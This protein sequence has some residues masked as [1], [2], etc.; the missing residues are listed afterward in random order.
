MITGEERLRENLSDLYGNVLGYEGQPSQTQVQRGDA[1]AGELADVTRDFDA[2]AARELSGLNSAAAKK[3]L[4]PLKVL[5]REE[6]ESKN[7]SPR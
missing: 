5:S 2:W 1:I 7:P 4:E 6:W 3:S